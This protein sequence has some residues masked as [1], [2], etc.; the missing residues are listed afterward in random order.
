MRASPSAPA[1]QVGFADR[2]G[3]EAGFEPVNPALAA[4]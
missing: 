2:G 4:H 3:G 1:V